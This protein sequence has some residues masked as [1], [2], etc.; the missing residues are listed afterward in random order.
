MKT[1]PSKT[2]N[3]NFFLFILLFPFYL[4][5]QLVPTNLY[6][7]DVLKDNKGKLKLQNPTLISSDNDG[8]YN[9]QPSFISDLLFVSAESRRGN[10]DII[11]YDY[12]KEKKSKLTETFEFNEYSP[13]SIPE[14]NYISAVVT[15]KDGNQN[16]FKFNIDKDEKPE[17][18]FP[19]V[20]N[21]GYHEWYSKDKV[22]LYLVLERGQ[23]LAMGD[24]STGKIRDL[25]T[26]TG[27]CLKR[28]NNGNIYFIQRYD[29]NN[30]KIKSH[31]YYGKPKQ[32]CSSLIGVEDFCLIGD[33]IFVMAKEGKIYT[34]NTEASET[35]ELLADLSAYGIQNISRM[36]YHDGKLVIVNKEKK[37]ID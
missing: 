23:K 11:V 22:L 6:M 7:F 2:C 18:L 26:N 8:K 34:Y 14:S 5:A 21:I 29:E 17:K 25:A 31:D 13:T 3:K 4:T 32:I 27:R 16:L 35:W 28:D 19:E 1:K 15:D 37:G 36:A 33:H 9:N 12:L 10:T 20:N 24:L 30:Y